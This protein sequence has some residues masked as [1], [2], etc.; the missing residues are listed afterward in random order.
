MKNRQLIFH[1]IG[2]R[3]AVLVGYFLYVEVL[4]DNL[5]QFKDNLNSSITEMLHNLTISEKSQTALDHR[6]FSREDLQSITTE[7]LENSLTQ[8]NDY[9]IFLL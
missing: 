8:V 2:R 9:L 6:M 5:A 7:I 4:L 3:T 1:K